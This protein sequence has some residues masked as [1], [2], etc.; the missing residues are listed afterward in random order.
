MPDLEAPP[1]FDERNATLA[2]MHNKIRRGALL[3]E[4]AEHPKLEQAAYNH[5]AWMAENATLN[6]IGEFGFKPGRRLNG[7]GF[8]W[9]AVAENIARDSRTCQE[10]MNYWMASAVHKRNILFREITLIGVCCLLSVDGERK[11]PYWCVVFARG[12]EI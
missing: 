11:T 6:H 5:C 12:A 2:E 3:T 7:I 8:A 4:L 10:V 1:D 9:G